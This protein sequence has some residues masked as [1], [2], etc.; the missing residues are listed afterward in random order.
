[1]ATQ[2]SP[3][4][5]SH[6]YVEKLA[7]YAGKIGKSLTWE[8]K[9]C[10]PAHNIDFTFCAKI[11]EQTFPEAQGKTK[12]DAKYSAAKI[13][14]EHLN[15]PD[16]MSFYSTSRTV[17]PAGI[18]N[19]ISK[20]NEYGQKRNIHIDYKSIQKDTGLEHVQQFSCRVFMD[21]KEYPIGLGRNKQEAKREAARLAYEIIFPNQSLSESLDT[22]DEEEHKSIAED[23]FGQ[24]PKSLTDDLTGES[25]ERDEDCTPTTSTDG[26]TSDFNSSM[27]NYGTRNVIGKLNEYC[28]KNTLTCETVE[29]D[30]RGPSHSPEFIIKF[31]INGKSFPSASGK[32]KQEAKRNAAHLALEELQNSGIS[33]E[34][35]NQSGSVSQDGFS[36]QENSKHSDGSSFIVFQNTSTASST[37]RVDITGGT[38]SKRRLAPTFNRLDGES[39]STSSQTNGNSKPNPSQQVKIEGFSNIETIGNGSFGHVYKA[40]KNLD[41]K[42]YAIKEVLLKNEKTVREV[43]SLA[44]MDHRNIVRYYNSWIGSSFF[45]TGRKALFIQM[46]LYEK[47]LREWIENAENNQP[48][49]EKVALTIFLQLLDGVIYIHQ[50][51]MVH[52]DLKPDNI[53]LTDKTE[54]KVGDFGLVVTMDDQKSL[55]KNIGTPRYMSPEQRNDEEYNHKVDIYAL[56]LIFFQLR[57]IRC[58]TVTESCKNWKEIRMGRLPQSFIEMCPCECL[59][60]RKMLSRAASERPEADEVKRYLESDGAPELKTI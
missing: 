42:S 23:S 47:N 49:Q 43:E 27:Q 55:T 58:G 18:G 5:A 3:E 29:V 22:G 12:K 6:T 17:S 20:I 41:K 9:V 26:S 36:L 14:F 59:L 37:P 15:L 32:N 28:Q 24:N 39:D 60:I 11:G 35:Q 7:L 25:K 19:Y 30:K 52:R 50:K 48:A 45:C 40:K 21:N 13:A 1:M 4:S 10:G 53:F 8:S 51:K 46:D 54:V 34:S 33:R 16:D 57:W 38:R 44:E 56:G 31:V 2:V